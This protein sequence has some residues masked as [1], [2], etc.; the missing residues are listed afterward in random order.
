MFFDLDEY[1]LKDGMNL[2]FLKTD[3]IILFSL[4]I[5]IMLSNIF[6]LKGIKTNP[7]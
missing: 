4:I 1:L 6:N 2:T 7:L 3:Q 5:N